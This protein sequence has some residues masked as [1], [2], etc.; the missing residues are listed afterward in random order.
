MCGK[1]D[2]VSSK[3]LKPWWNAAPQECV[4]YLLCIMYYVFFIMYHLSWSMH[5][6][7]YYV[8]SNMNYLFCSIDSVLF[9]MTCLLSS[10]H[11]YYYC[12][13]LVLWSWGGWKSH[14]WLFCSFY[15]MWLGNQIGTGSPLNAVCVSECYSYLKSKSLVILLIGGC[16]ESRRLRLNKKWMRLNIRL[17]GYCQPSAPM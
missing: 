2:V 7:V 16:G 14:V 12:Y 5:Y 6:V 8:F 10:I 11:I 1:S 3:A 4:L 13:V 17:V 9:D 15:E